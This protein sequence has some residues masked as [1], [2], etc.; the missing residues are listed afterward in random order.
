MRRA[1]YLVL[2]LVFLAVVGTAA[3]FGF[4]HWKQRHL[5]RLAD[6]F[7][8]KSDTTNAVLCLQQALRCDSSNVRACQMFAEMA[9]R[10]GSRNAIY[11]RHRVVE[12]E[13]GVMQPRIDLA[14]TALVMGDFATAQEALRSV[15]ES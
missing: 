15:G 1:I 2:A 7:L 9:E 4:R 10:A 5:I 14:K 11:W 3:R 13:P 12:L 8:A 6:K